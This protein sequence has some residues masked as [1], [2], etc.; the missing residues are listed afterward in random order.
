[1]KLE[2]SKASSV[3]DVLLR[4]ALLR[5]RG[6]TRDAYAECAAFAVLGEL[7]TKDM[8]ALAQT[9]AEFARSLCQADSAGI[10]VLDR[11]GAREVLRLDAIAGPLAPHVG[12]RLARERSP[13][14]TAIDRNATLLF[15]E[16]GRWFMALRQVVPAIHETLVVPWTVGGVATGSLWVVAHAP[17]ERF[18]AA[19]AQ[20]LARLGTFVAAAHRM[21][22]A[23]E[24]TR[25]AREASRL[26]DEF[27]VTLAHELSNPLSS[28]NN[29]T[30]LLL[31]TRSTGR[32]PDNVVDMLARQVHQVIRL[33][34]DLQ[35][36]SRIARGKLA[37]DLKPTVLG[38]A[39]RGALDAC[40]PLFEQARQPLTVSLPE[41]PIVLP[42]DGVR[43]TQIIAN[44]LHNATRYS[45]TGKPVALTVSCE[46]PADVVISVRDCGAGIE[47][48]QLAHIFEMYAQAHRDTRNGRRGLGI[49]LAMVRK[50][51]ELHGGRV[52][53]HSA[54]P[55]CGS[56]FVVRLPRH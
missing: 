49:G 39:V 27:V 24:A 56:E 3:D 17:G 54:G 32:V 25:R 52:E 38:E 16:P 15:D 20:L 22:G 1:M 48:A 18:T 55:G 36:I 50:L 44:L 34:D 35:D 13:C 41:E 11:E 6:G 30:T 23:L 53:A 19:D 4:D 31:R 9:A 10:C 46:E 51:V 12:L 29:A 40:M 37:L 7:L 43:L 2:G 28:I 33:V 21:S 5:R 45:E 42:A 47:P 14:G 8:A 26:T